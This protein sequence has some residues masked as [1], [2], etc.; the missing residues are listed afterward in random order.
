MIK[1]VS[2]TPENIIIDNKETPP[3]LYHATLFM[4]LKD[5]QEDRIKPAMQALFT[6]LQNIFTQ[7]IENQINKKIKTLANVMTENMNRTIGHI[8]ENNA[9]LRTQ[10]VDLSREVR[11]TEA[12]KTTLT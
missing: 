7:Q 1:N 12:V 8:R 5:L 2:R 6:T 11:S 4:T 3:S 10:V 9:R